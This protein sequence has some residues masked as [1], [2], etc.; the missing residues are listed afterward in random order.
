[1]RAAIT[2]ALLMLYLDSAESFAPNLV[3]HRA[4]RKAPVKLLVFIARQH[5]GTTQ[6]LKHFTK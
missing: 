3:G 6:L 1:M 4:A 5:P 2:A